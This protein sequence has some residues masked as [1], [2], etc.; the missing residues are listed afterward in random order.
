MAHYLLILEAMIILIYID[1]TY[2]TSNYKYIQSSESDYSAYYH[3]DIVNNQI[4]NLKNL[5]EETKKTIWETSP[6]QEEVLDHFPNMIA[7]Q[8]IYNDRIEDNGAFKQAFFIHMK[9][10][11]DDYIAGQ[12]NEEEFKE[13]FLAPSF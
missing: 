13:Q 1:I 5:P 4:L 6:I 10:L 12:I 2:G 7:M 3:M 8:E 9:S 11:Q